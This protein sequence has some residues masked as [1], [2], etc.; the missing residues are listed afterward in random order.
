MD[1]FLGEIRIVAFDYAPM[2][3]ALC[4]GQLLSISQNSA[5]FAL[6]G[7]TYGGD[8]RNTFGLPDFRG[9]APVHIG[10]GLYQGTKFG[11]ETHTLIQSEMPS[12][13][14]RLAGV[15][16]TATLTNPDGAF[17]AAPPFNIY[18]SI[19]ATGN[20]AMNDQSVGVSGN[21]QAHNNMQPFLVM[22]FVIATQGIFPPR[23]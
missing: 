3:W 16:A 11:E 9:R 5:L 7:T 23:S 20:V 17:L 18:G 4:N 21:S 1:P 6:L 12:H 10:Q 13:S 19:S 8:G 22:N 2:G 14:H 15:Q